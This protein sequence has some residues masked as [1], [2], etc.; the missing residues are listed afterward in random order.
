RARDAA[1]ARGDPRVIDERS[2]EIDAAYLCHVVGVLESIRSHPLG[3]RVAG[4]AEERQATAFIA[5][6]R[7]QS[8]LAEVTEEAVPVDGWRL[9][10]AFV[11]L[12]DGTR[13]ECASFGGVPETGVQ[14][15]RGALVR[16]GRGG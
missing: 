10:D 14:G 7:R 12:E 5:A 13:Y 9:R 8:G 4:T 2:L 15:V 6:E 1:R 11:E 3:F 16:V